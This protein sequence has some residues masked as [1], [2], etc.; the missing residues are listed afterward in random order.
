MGHAAMRQGP[1]SPGR[2]GGGGALLTFSEP[3]FIC[4]IV[5]PP[6]RKEVE[7]SVSACVSLSLSFSP[8]LSLSLSHLTFIFLLSL[9]LPLFLRS[10]R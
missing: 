2:S 7:V 3:D 10:E 6:D 8:S 1:R 5:R 4:N 9:S